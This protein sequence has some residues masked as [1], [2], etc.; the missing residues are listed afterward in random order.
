MINV[1]RRK[2]LRF[3]FGI[4]AKAKLYIKFLFYLCIDLLIK[5][6]KLISSRTLLII[7]P[8]AIGD[9][10]LF[11][12]F[13]KIIR[14]SH[15]FRDYKI[16]L[17]GNIAW[18]DF[19]LKLDSKNI[20][21]FLWI[22]RKKFFRNFSYR[23]SK[24]KEITKIGYE[25]VVHPVHS[26]EFFV[27]DNIVKL[28]KSDHKIGCVGDYGNLTK[29]TKNIS[30]R[31]Y[32]KL[33]DTGEDVM[34][35]FDRNKLFCE[36]FLKNTIP[37]TKFPNI[38]SSFINSSFDLPINYIVLFIGGSTKSKK[39]PVNKFAELAK[40]IKTKSLIKSHTIILCGSNEEI[41]ESL[42][43]QKLYGDNFINLVGKTSLIDMLNI[44]HKS[45]YLISNETSIP[46]LALAVGCNKIVIIY[47]GNHFGRFIPLD[48][49]L[50]TL[51]YALHPVI[52][53]NPYEYKVKSNAR[54]YV[55]T[56]DINQISINEVV[57]KLSELI[58]Y[59]S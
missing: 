46:H 44:L 38:S 56:L 4:A 57:A 29:F 52:K 17:L 59:D 31:F 28:I 43:F 32:S 33:I 36:I 5:P 13:L 24:L 45:K 41:E 9:Y 21:D 47:S 1:L 22:D 18:K 25:V 8:D 51:K 19:A 11:R 14:E 26:R 20:D 54:G 58:A 55:S 3:K 42:N 50:S 39:W 35:E 30:D 48:G 49:R 12:N 53:N 40:Y 27:G 23:K 37:T 15:K 2:I 10:I 16:T 34:Y 7:R 6:N